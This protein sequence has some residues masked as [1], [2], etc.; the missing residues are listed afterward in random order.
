MHIAEKMNG[1]VKAPNA[2]Q[3]Q[4]CMCFV[5]GVNF[6]SENIIWFSSLFLWQ[7]SYQ[8]I[9]LSQTII[10]LFKKP[11]SNAQTEGRIT[12]KLLQIHIH[13]FVQIF[14]R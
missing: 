1:G 6:I 2:G 12:S 4:V 3:N 8:K 13:I 9:I 11:N 14:Y 10:T 5:N 7:N